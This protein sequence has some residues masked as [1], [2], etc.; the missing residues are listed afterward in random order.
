MFYEVRYEANK[1]TE[2]FP[3]ESIMYAGF[4]AVCVQFQKGRHTRK[5]DNLLT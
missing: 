1:L 3:T 5:K 4:F 2:F